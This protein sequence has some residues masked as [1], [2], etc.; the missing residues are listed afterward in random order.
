M[1]GKGFGGAMYAAEGQHDFGEFE[2]R[3]AV[4]E[5]DIDS[6]LVAQAERYVDF[7]ATQGWRRGGFL[8]R[9]RGAVGAG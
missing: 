2:R 5:V 7:A 6:L 9:Y 3:V 8:G 4:I 1:L